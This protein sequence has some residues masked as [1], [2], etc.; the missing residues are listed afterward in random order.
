MI[1]EAIEH[2]QKH[3]EGHI[4]PEFIRR[5]GDPPYV[6]FL[7]KGNEVERQEVTAPLRTVGLLRI[8]DLVAVA[9]KHF[10]SRITQAET[11]VFFNVHQI[12][13]IFNTRNGYERARVSLVASKEHTFFTDRRSAPRI[14][15]RELRGALRYNLADCFDNPALEDQISKLSITRHDAGNEEHGRGRE[16]L[17]NEVMTEAQQEAGLPEAIQIFNVRRW[18]NPDLDV[19]HPIKCVLDPDL[20]TRQWLLVPNEASYAEYI[21]LSL[22]VIEQRLRAGLKDCG[23]PVYQGAFATTAES[24]EG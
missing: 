4:K 23:V 17:G 5:P 18:A 19:R 12:E 20:E 16:S 15:V 22:E 24:A 6:I 8:D 14:G 2:V 3:A 21:R 9:T 1:K 11:A 10:D 13:L 7:R